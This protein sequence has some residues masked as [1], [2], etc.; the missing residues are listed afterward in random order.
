MTVPGSIIDPIVIG[1]AAKPPPIRLP[2][3]KS[4]FARRAARFAALAS[5]TGMGQFLAFM[6]ELARAQ[7]AALER[8]PTGTLPDAAM[9]AVA[10]E[11]GLA[12]LDRGLWRRDASWR[13]AFDDILEHMT[14]AGLTPE[15]AAAVRTLRNLPA[16]ALEVLATRA[17][18]FEEG[19]RDPAQACFLVAALQVYWVRMAG[20]LDAEDVKPASGGSACPVC[21]APPL[22][23][24]V[25]STGALT[26][27]RFL[28]CAL[29]ATEWHLVRIKCANCDSTKGI[30]Y[31]EIEGG[32]GSVKAETCD[33]C[34]TYTKILYT[35]KDP[36]AE[37]FADD[38]ATLGLDVLVNEAGWH[39]AHPN[40]FLIPGAD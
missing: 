29:C 6:A 21:G 5:A 10:G 36:E 13:H 4:V 31:H 33:E 40:P 2:D 7:A 25:Y 27:T 20:L 28:L 37:P 9:L 30:A 35:E 8:L 24:V 34:R 18:H 32:K 22:A 14:Q 38:L 26:G 1:N 23:S 16:D 17:A 12:P 3:L 15:A 19:G 11:R 39:R